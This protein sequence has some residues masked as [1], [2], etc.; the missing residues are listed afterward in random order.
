VQFISRVLLALR[1]PEFQVL[2]PLSTGVYPSRRAV[3]SVAAAAKTMTQ[4][5]HCLPGVII[6]GAGASSRMGR[7]KLLLPW[8]RVSIVGHLIQ[9]WR[10]LQA[11]QIALVCAAG[12]QD[13]QA[14][15]DR[16]GVPKPDRIFN[17]APERG[18]F[19]SIQCAARWSGWKPQLT[20][21]VIGLGDQPHVRS[22]TLRALLDF[23]AAQPDRICQ[24]SFNGRPRHPVILPRTEFELLKEARVENLKLFLQS[25]AHIVSLLDLDDPG[26]AF[27]IDRP[28]DYARA[29]R[30]Y[31]ERE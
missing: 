4:S 7:P 23:K 14:E 25:R 15:L 21:W 1:T 19:S 6:L 10:E 27:D 11:A 12:D 8:G 24:P 28:G 22:E 16:L 2:T 3:A 29:V 17:P 5:Y 9:Q 20:D 30:L 13:L 26:L 31:C 18:M